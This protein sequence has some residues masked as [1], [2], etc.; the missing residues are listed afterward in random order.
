MTR[1]SK[2]SPPVR[3]ALAALAAFLAARAEG[4]LVRYD[5]RGHIDMETTSGPGSPASDFRGT[6]IYDDAVT[7]GPSH[8]NAS[9]A[10]ERTYAS[11]SHRGDDASP[12]GTMLQIWFNDK[13]V[14]P[15][16][17]GLSGVL[18]S[19]K[20]Y[21]GRPRSELTFYS[22]PREDD[23]YL[24]DG[25]ALSVTF[26]VDPSLL[27]SG[28]FPEGL[29]VGDLPQARI[30]ITGVMNGQFYYPDFGYFGPIDSFAITPV[31]EPAWSVAVLLGAAAWMVR[32]RPSR[33]GDRGILKWPRW[34][35]HSTSTSGA[36]TACSESG[37]SAM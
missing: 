3:L 21:D 31:P 15:A 11:G 6:L 30:G 25:G 17:S 4:S 29:T 20:D 34:R 23:G 35:A 5:F 22:H 28:R 8:R 37:P 19:L 33:I 2:T 9:G 14:A 12:D 16:S 18:F 24:R 10:E 13:A 1:S 26:N 27:A 36:R 32:R 7:F